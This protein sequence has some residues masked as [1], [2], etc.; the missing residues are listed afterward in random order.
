MQ[1]FVRARFAGSK[2]HSFKSL[3][4]VFL[5]LEIDLCSAFAKFFAKVFLVTTYAVGSI[6]YLLPIQP[7]F[8]VFKP[9]S[10]ERLVKANFAHLLDIATEC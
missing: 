1:I 9:Q 6:K 5:F 2:T 4:R 7:D 3:D 10:R 8:T